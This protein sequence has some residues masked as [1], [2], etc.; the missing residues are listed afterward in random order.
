MMKNVNSNKL[1]FGRFEWK[2]LALTFVFSLFLILCTAYSW[3]YSGSIFLTLLCGWVAFFCVL[4]GLI[5]SR[6]F[7]GGHDNALK[8]GLLAALL[9]FFICGL[10]IMALSGLYYLFIARD[11]GAFFAHIDLI[12]IAIFVLVLG[13]LACISWRCVVL[14]VQASQQSKQLRQTESQLEQT[15]KQVELA[16]RN[17]MAKLLFEASALMED[18][19]D[20]K[21]KAALEILAQMSMADNGYFSHAALTIMENQLEGVT[22]TRALYEA[23]ASFLYKCLKHVE[24]FHRKHNTKS[25]IALKMED[26]LFGQKP[27]ERTIIFSRANYVSCYFHQMDID[28]DSALASFRT[29]SFIGC[30]VH[31]AFAQ[32]KD[33][34]FLRSKI[35]YF[36]FSES[37]REGEYL[38]FGE[39]DFSACTYFKA[40]AANINVPQRQDHKNYIYE[41]ATVSKNVMS[42]LPFEILVRDKKY[43]KNAGQNAAVLTK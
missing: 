19:K 28:D 13:F 12:K 36:D 2:K 42:D 23:P 4:A 24:A 8:G 25:K 37:N 18:E 40:R 16:D 11:M 10:M 14:T 34:K 1:V 39:C 20:A 26:V 31:G 3:F 29:C 27:E 22:I 32:L 41:G 33:C 35:L 30:T 43:N 21:R 6:D 17:S 38:Y 9:I 7:N 5:N 15:Q